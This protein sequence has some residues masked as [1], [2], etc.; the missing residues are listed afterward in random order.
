M[1]HVVRTIAALI[2]LLGLV[3]GAIAQQFF[4]FHGRVLWVAGTTM[5]FVP[6]E[7]GA[8]DVDLSRLDQTQYMFLRS[9]EPVWVVGLITLDGNKVIAYRITADRYFWGS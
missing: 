8:F 6:D 5:G 9:G 7:G 2:L 3:G 1:R 4:S